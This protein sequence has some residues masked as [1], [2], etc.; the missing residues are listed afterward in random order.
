MSIEIKLVGGKVGTLKKNIWYIY[1][2]DESIFHK[3]HIR[4]GI[5]ILKV[6]FEN[7]P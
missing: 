7:V 5:F 6:D 3:M 4:C 2:I 1:L